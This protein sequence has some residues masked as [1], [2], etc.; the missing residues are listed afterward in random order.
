MVKTEEIKFRVSSDMKEGLMGKAG[1]LGVS[2]SEYLRGLIRGDVIEMGHSGSQEYKLKGGT[3]AV[4]TTTEEPK[5]E[6][7][8]S[9]FKK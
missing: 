5:E 8:K 9:Y 4:N 6:Q 2:M 3:A 7:F 1:A